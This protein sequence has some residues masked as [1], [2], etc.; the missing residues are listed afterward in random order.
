M[1]FLSIALWCV[2]S[3]SVELFSVKYCCIFSFTMFLSYFVLKRNVKVECTSSVQL[4]ELSQNGYAC[5]IIARIWKQSIISTLE[6][7]FYCPFKG[8]PPP[9][10]EVGFSPHSLILPDFW[11]HINGSIFPFVSSFFCPVLCLLDSPS[12]SIQLFFFFAR[13]CFIALMLLV[14]VFSY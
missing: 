7:P 8:N 14:I 5:V 11:T 2:K 10:P 4:V 6:I 3:K 13:F 12:Y 1:N 9:L